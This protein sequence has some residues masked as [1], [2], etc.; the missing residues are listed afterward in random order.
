[1][2]V[3]VCQQAVIIRSS[4]IPNYRRVSI[5][6][7]THR[8]CHCNIPIEYTPRRTKNIDVNYRAE[9]ASPP[10][11]RSQI[12]VLFIMFITARETYLMDNDKII[13]GRSPETTTKTQHRKSFFE[14]NDLKIFT[15]LTDVT[16]DC[17]RAVILQYHSNITD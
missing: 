1:M 10:D 15:N 8:Q 6:L 14:E 9:Q 4:S 12:L 16:R 7:H 11:G 13:V 5:T 3:Q 2:Q 17:K